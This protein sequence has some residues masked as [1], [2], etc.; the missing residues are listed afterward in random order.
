[1][2]NPFSQL[3]NYKFMKRNIAWWLSQFGFR[4]LE[5]INAFRELPK[6]LFDY[7][8]FRRMNNESIRV[9]FTLPCLHDRGTSSGVAYGHYFHQ[10]LYV[11][12][13]IFNRNP[14][15]HV[16]IGSRLDGFVAHVA[17]FR[18]IEILDIRDSF[19]NIPGIRFNKL[20]LTNSRS[21]CIE[22]TDSLSCLHA[23]EHFG[24]GRY[25]DPVDPNG[26]RKGL[27]NMINMLLPEGIFYL[28]V[29]MGE[30]RIE[31]N[32]HRIFSIPTVMSMCDD[33]R[34]IEF[35]WV[36]DDGH[37]Y[38]S[39]DMDIVKTENYFGQRYGLGIYTFQK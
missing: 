38:E 22:Y 12:R 14:T 19:N 23:L 34:L 21:K 8:K 1:M 9:S 25:G 32:G 13:K 31:F 36:G 7:L 5:T 18:E 16:D 24:L 10:D 30:D 26:H 4:P 35:A 39:N 3:N 37:L 27:A 11:A 2:G 28:S 15:T 20:D 17:T 6:V 33:L 29:P